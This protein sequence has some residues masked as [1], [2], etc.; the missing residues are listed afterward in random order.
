V[1]AHL[2]VDLVPAGVALDVGD[3]DLRL[4]ERTA[5]ADGRGHDVLIG[6]VLV[7]P[8]VELVLEIGALFPGADL[9]AL[10][11]LQVVEMRT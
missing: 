11:D 7:D 1:R 5:A 9:L 2:H 4:A 10:K 8:V 3:R 6:D